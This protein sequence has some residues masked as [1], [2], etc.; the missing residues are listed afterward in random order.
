MGVEVDV[1]TKSE[2]KEC[3]GEGEE[4]KKG[5]KK[6]KKHSL[7]RDQKRTEMMAEKM[8][9]KIEAVDSDQKVSVSGLKPSTKWKEV[10]E[11]FV[12]N[13][14]EVDLCDITEPGAAVVTFKS[15]G[16][17][18]SAIATV[19]ATDLD[20]NTIKVDSWTG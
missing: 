19:N 16:D 17:A 1:W 12:S 2:K 11:H 13:G 6:V 4:K 5:K 15:A 8:A 20:G 14:C 7:K 9:A 3:G 10:K 18:T